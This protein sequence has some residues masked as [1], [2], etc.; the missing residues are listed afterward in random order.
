MDTKKEIEL[1][2]IK[3]VEKDD[4][5]NKPLQIPALKNPNS[6]E[7]VNNMKPPEIKKPRIPD[8]DMEYRERQERGTCG[9]CSTTKLCM[10]CCCCCCL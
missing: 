6:L 4:S 7:N 1:E 9:D 2:P 8:F 10:K 3:H 5:I